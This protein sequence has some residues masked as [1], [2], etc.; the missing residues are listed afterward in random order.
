MSSWHGSGFPAPTQGSFGAEPGPGGRGIPE[1]HCLNIERAEAVGPAGL[2][3][4]SGGHS[5]S[6]PQFPHL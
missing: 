5:C 2:C 6:E 3:L 4:E 1:T